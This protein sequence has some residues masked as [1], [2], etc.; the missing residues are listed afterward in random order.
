MNLRFI[1]PEDRRRSGGSGAGT[2]WADTEPACFRSEAFAEDL[3]H[4]GAGGAIAAR[5][6]RRLS[7]RLLRGDPGW[8]SVIGLALIAAFGLGVGTGD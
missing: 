1:R 7:L 6:S 3:L 8:A 5:A 2:D 4:E